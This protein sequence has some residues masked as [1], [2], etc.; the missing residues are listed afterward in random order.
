MPIRKLCAGCKEKLNITRVIDECCSWKCVKIYRRKI[1]IEIEFL[2][3]K[4]AK[5]KTKKKV[6]DES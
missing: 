6:D 4:L 2:D 5:R 1:K 3:H